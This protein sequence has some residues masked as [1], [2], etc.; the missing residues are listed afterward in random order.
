MQ[1]S[2]N[3]EITSTWNS[4]KSSTT[5]ITIWLIV[6]FIPIV[7]IVFGYLCLSQWACSRVTVDVLIL[8]GMVF[9]LSV[10]LT[11]LTPITFAFI[12]N[13]CYP[14]ILPAPPLTSPPRS[15]CLSFA[16]EYENP[17]NSGRSRSRSG[18]RGRSNSP[19]RIV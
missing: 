3:N 9:G 4:I 11:I 12:L 19:S 13:G 6:L 15:A 16:E 2:L 17:L 18:S 14:R 5:Y 8:G 10:A 1:E 7:L